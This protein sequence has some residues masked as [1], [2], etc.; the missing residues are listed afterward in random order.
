M[1]NSSDFT[2]S[3]IEVG[4][5]HSSGSVEQVEILHPSPLV[6]VTF[7]YLALP[8]GLFLGSWFRLEVAVPGIISLL[9]ITCLLFRT[10]RWLPISRPPLLFWIAILI[11]SGWVFISGIGHFVYA[12]NDWLVRDAVLRDLVVEPWPVLYQVDDSS[13]F[14]L[15]APLG[16]YL[17]AA[18]TGK[19]TGVRMAHTILSVWTG[20]GVVL[21]FLLIAKWFSSQKKKV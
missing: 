15:R 12:N 9:V 19:L 8:V 16:Y 18:V 2:T 17:P 3:T 7:L 20:I 1:N 21:T 5:I 10:T 14:I 4:S 6:F 11:S 13:I